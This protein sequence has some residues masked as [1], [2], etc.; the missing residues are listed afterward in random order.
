MLILQIDAT[1]LDEGDNAMISYKIESPDDDR[2]SMDNET[3]GTILMMAL[4]RNFKCIDNYFN[5]LTRE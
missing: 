5:L 2:F 1:D 4:R 3:V